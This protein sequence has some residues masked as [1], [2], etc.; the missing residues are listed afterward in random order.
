MQAL[1]R[2]FGK[3]AVPNPALDHIRSLP[4][5]DVTV[6]LVSALPSLA[7]ELLSEARKQA[8]ALRSQNSLLVECVLDLEL[9]GALD[10]V[11][12]FTNDYDLASIYVDAIVFEATNKGP[13]GIPAD[14]EFKATGTEQHRGIAKYSV[15]EK[16]FNVGDP[17]AW[18]FGKEYS[19]IMTGS[20]L[21]IA[22]VTPVGPTTLIIRQYGAW[23]TDYALTGKVPGKEEKDAFLAVIERSNKALEELTNSLRNL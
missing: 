8:K 11:A 19:K 23:M 10:R 22:Y 12:K 4:E 6:K 16:Y 21:D 3:S 7:R 2:F 14:L 20:A 18:L 1:E 13:S 9:V 5:K 15:A 17:C